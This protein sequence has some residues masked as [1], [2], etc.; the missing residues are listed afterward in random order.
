[1][2]KKTKTNKAK[3]IMN[4]IEQYPTWSIADIAKKVNATASYV[5][6]I[7]KDW[8][9]AFALTADMEEPATDMNDLFYSMSQG[10]G[11]EPAADPVNSPPH[12][13]GGGIE[14]IDYIQAKL[15][16]E[17]FRG[18]CLGNSIKYLSRAGK[19]GDATTDLKKAQWYIE[20]VAQA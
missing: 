5:Y 16:E 13:T 1:M 2:P 8:L 3:T 7:R 19:K 20:R 17:E 15:S 12:Y 6:K 18:Y 11:G 10:T 14:T 4:L 9:D